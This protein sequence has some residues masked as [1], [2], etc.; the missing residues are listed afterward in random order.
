MISY[1]EDQIQDAVKSF[2]DLTDHSNPELEIDLQKS[3]SELL[4]ND[5]SPAN[6]RSA[7]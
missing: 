3:L 4:S 2:R 6:R 7:Q 1:H 5:V